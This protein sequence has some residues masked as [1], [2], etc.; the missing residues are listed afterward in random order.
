LVVDNLLGY[1]WRRVIHR[2]GDG[3]KYPVQRVHSSL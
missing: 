1:D 3:V 2:V